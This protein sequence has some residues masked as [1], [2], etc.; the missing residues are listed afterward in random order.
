MHAS[1]GSLSSLMLNCQPEFAKKSPFEIMPP[2]AHASI[3]P[4]NPTRA[5]TISTQIDWEAHSPAQVMAGNGVLSS[6]VTPIAMVIVAGNMFPQC[7]NVF[8]QRVIDQQCAAQMGVDLFGAVENQLG[9]ALIELCAR[10][11]C[12][13]HEAADI[14]GVCPLDPRLSDLCVDF[15]VRV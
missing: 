15:S 9:P 10:P 12:A 8:I 13:A 5:T 7:S 2:N 3:R 11:Q 4:W 1:R 6:F 14:C